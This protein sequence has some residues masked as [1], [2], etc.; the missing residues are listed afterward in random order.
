V[1][2]R[3]PDWKNKISDGTLNLNTPQVADIFARMLLIP[4]RGF[5]T[6]IVHGDGLR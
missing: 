5:R 6:G 3:E 2:A 4:E 1:V